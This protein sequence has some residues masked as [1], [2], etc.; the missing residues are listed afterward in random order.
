MSQTAERLSDLNEQIRAIQAE[1]EA[2]LKS[3]NDALLAAQV[4]NKLLKASLDRAVEARATS[5]RVCAKL[6][7][8][9]GTVEAVFAQAKTLAEEAAKIPAEGPSE[10]TLNM[11]DAK[12][13]V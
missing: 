2:A 4:E 3:A 1:H 13:E 10:E 11:A 7:A 8:Q 12:G 9:F 5:E 6:L